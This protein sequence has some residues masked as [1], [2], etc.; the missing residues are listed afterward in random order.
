[1]MMFLTP[2]HGSQ[3]PLAAFLGFALLLS[4]CAGLPASGPASADIE[5]A[6]A[7]T[8]Q[9]ASSI[10]IIDISDAVARQ[11]L[12]KAQRSKF[13]DT[14]AQPG[15]K[16][17]TV[18][19]GDVLEVTVWEAPPASLFG[20]GMLDPRLA[21]GAAG[22][23]SVL[24]AQVISADGTINVPFAG[25]ILAAGQ[26]LPQVEAEIVRR[27][28]GKA[29]Q[30][31]VLVRLV[32]NVSA[33]VTI[34]GEV[35]Q[36]IRMPLT[37]RGERLLDAIAASGGVR[38]PVNKVTVQVTR[39]SEVGSMPLEAVIRDPLQNV[40]LQPGDVVTVLFQPLSFT[41]LG[42][43]GRNEEIPFEAT[44]LTLAQALGRTGGLNDN[45]ADAQG[46]FIFRLEAQD[47]LAWPRQP[48]A[49]TPE[50][51]VPVVYRLDLKNPG[52]FF[53]A[54]GFAIKDKDV[55][56]VSN[57]PAA[58]LQKFLN[59]ITSVVYPAIGIINLTR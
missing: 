18:A 17:G 59:L 39:G 44:G 40:Q 33:N 5:A 48:V 6:G 29:N 56:Y 15:L 55:L 16:P 58:E 37:P 3:W 53:V 23:P 24:P 52:S 38:H 41:A 12:S 49:T 2:I 42:A 54:Q 25:A 26:T 4:G 20:S 51:K 31:Q 21:V 13:A 36:S 47:A 27:L 28:N 57:A 1:M 22:G 19:P 45:R 35:A 11:L 10:Q 50:G 7:S 32:G 9:A 30:P 34:V 14:L 43:T 8:E 46:I